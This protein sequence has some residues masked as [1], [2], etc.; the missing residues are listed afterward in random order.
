[1][2]PGRPW[3]MNHRELQLYSVVLPAVSKHDEERLSIR[4]KSDVTSQLIT[5]VASLSN[6]DVPGKN[7]P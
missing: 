3:C 5:C 2:I 7:Y 6:K 4:G 1:V